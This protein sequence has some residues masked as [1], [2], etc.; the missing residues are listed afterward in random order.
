MGM[1]LWDM[2]ERDITF[3]RRGWGSSLSG[4]LSG[5]PSAVAD[6]YNEDD[7]ENMDPLDEEQEPYLST[8]Q[9][10][11]PPPPQRERVADDGMR[12]K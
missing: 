7:R 2:D 8:P 6:Y 11:I 10:H 5:G 3:E 12:E 1:T 4:V 9:A